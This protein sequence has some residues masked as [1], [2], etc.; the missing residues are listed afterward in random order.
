MAVHS[1]HGSDCL[2]EVKLTQSLQK[3]FGY[4]SF[5]PGQLEASLSILHGHDVFVRMVTGSGKTLCMFLGPL[6][7]SSKVIAVIINGLM[8]QSIHSE[9]SCGQHQ[10]QTARSYKPSGFHLRDTSIT[11]LRDVVIN[12]SQIVLMEDRLDNNE[13]RNTS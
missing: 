8:E 6:A 2:C 12:I 3:Y 5:R 7:M 4:T 9:Q 13:R 11:N 1:C 10:T